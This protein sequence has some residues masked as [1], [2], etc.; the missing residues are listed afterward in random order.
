MKII[1]SVAV[2]ALVAQLVLHGAATIRA[3]NMDWRDA[4][5]E[6]LRGERGLA[7]S[8]A[9][10]LKKYVDGTQ[11]QKE[12]GALE[13]TYKRAKADS[14]AVIDD[15]ITVLLDG[16]TPGRELQDRL[17]R[18]IAGLDEFCGTVW[19]LIPATTGQ[20]G[21]PDDFAEAIK[22][23]WAGIAALTIDYVPDD[24]QKRRMFKSQLEAQKWLT[25][26]DVKAAQ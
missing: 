26:S 18:S 16:K 3:E 7:E 8:C 23:L 11:K 15:L 14:D 2:S 20:K 5:V 12:S 4:A 25:F 1:P 19:K 22:K 21:L 24:P 13:G 6:Q 10:R 9:A 17:G